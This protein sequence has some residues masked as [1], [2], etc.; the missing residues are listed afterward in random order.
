MDLKTTYNTI[1]EDWVKD[2]DKDTWWQEGTEYFLSLLPKESTV[3]DVGC[4]GGIKTRY[5]SDKGYDATGIDFS[6]K[7]IEIAK[8]ENPGVEFGVVDMYD[9]DTIAKTFD[10]IFVQAALLHIPKAQVMEVLTKMKDKLNPNGLLYIAVKGIRED[11]VEEG[12]KTENDY[13]YDYQR[14]FSYF[15]LE[16][17]KGYLNTLDLEIVWEG[18]RGSNA[19]NWIQIIGKKK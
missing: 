10:G 13:G 3:L 14:F 17:L 6:D 4:G 9:V 8:R 12:I 15:T 2:H 11:G 5:I 18:N 1:A 7:M 19:T 16:E